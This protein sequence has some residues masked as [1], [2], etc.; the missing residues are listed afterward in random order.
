MI[1]LPDLPEV[2][3]NVKLPLHL[4]LFGRTLRVIFIKCTAKRALIQDQTLHMEGQLHVILYF[5]EVW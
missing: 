2:E 3:N 1:C 5:R 4:G